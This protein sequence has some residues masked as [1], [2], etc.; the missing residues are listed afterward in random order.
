[1]IPTCLNCN[2]KLPTNKDI[3]PC[4]SECYSKPKIRELIEKLTFQ[5]IILNNMT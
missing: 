3:Y 1:M 4:C 2:K 5:E